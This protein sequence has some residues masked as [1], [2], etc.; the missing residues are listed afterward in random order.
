MVISSD[1]EVVAANK[2]AKEIYGEDI[3]G[4]KCYELCYGMD[5]RCPKCKLLEILDGE[6]K[7]E[8]V[9][10][11]NFYVEDKVTIFPLTGVDCV[12]CMVKLDFDIDG[13]NKLEKKLYLSNTFLHNLILSSVDAVIAAD[14]KGKIFIFNDV[15]SKI[16]GYTREEALNEVDIR[17]LYPGDGA[18]DV[19]KKLRSKE[20]GGPGKLKSF[21]VELLTKNKEVVPV[22]LN[23]SIIYENGMEVATIGFFR[24]LRETLKMERELEEARMQL[25]QSSKMAAIG[26]LAAGV[27]HQLNNPLSGIIL[28][29]ELLL[30]EDLDNHIKEDI[31]RILENAKRCKETVKELLEFSRQPENKK[32]FVNINKAIDRTIFLMERHPLLKDI[33]I[34]RDYDETIPDIKCDGQQLNHVFMNIIWNAVQAMEGKGKLYVKTSRL[35]DNNIKI[36]I[37]DTG[38]GINEEILPYIFDPFFST[39]RQGQGVG[40]G[41]SI[42]YRIIDAHSGKILAY[43]KEGGGACFEIILPIHND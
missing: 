3:I 23:A 15:A 7:K 8:D 21:R 22:E 25:Y 38:P 39:K 29:S 12:Q 24:D 37:C 41:L 14:K 4:K 9:A 32:F 36:S 18:R 35:E 1:L 16:L 26:N 33:E 43:N 42:A 10:F 2:F 20:Y 17:D 6:E 19:M 11:T 40:L 13:M 31:L 27:A 34:I 28:F 5:K 30:E